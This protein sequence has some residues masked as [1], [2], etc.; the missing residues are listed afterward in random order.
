MHSSSIL[1]VGD[2]IAGITRARIGPTSFGFFRV[3]CRARP[4]LA[5][6]PRIDRPHRDGFTQIART[7][8]STS[9]VRRPI[10]GL[11]YWLHNIR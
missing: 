7:L 1:R 11:S 6:V 8:R 10:F 9:Q 3:A 4:S 2:E 5:T